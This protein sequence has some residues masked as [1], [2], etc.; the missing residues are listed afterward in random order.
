[1]RMW[2]VDVKKMCRK[3]LLGEH[4]EMHMFVSSVK[5]GKSLQGF[6]NTGLVEV[7][8]IKKRHDELVQEMLF[9]GYKH[10]TPLN[11]EDFYVAGSVDIE[12][13]ERELSRRCCY[14]AL[15]LTKSEEKRII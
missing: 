14:C 15:P 12:E 6:I 13:N 5:N 1:M 2:N 10:K 8:N 7:H 9:R 11:Y 4:V 3:H